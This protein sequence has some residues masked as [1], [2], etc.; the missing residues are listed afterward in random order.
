ML[1][2]DVIAAAL[3]HNGYEDVMTAITLGL[4]LWGEARGYP[5]AVFHA[6]QRIALP[7]SIAIL[8]TKNKL[9]N[10]LFKEMD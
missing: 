7:L 5:D 3:E 10:E 9:K 6:R 8:E 1:F 2:K 4:H